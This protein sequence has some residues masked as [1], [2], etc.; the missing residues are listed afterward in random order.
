MSSGVP[1]TFC[2]KHPTWPP[3]YVDFEGSA[4]YHPD[5]APTSQGGL[6]KSL[7]ID[8]GVGSSHLHQPNQPSIYEPVEQ[9]RLTSYSVWDSVQILISEELGKI[10]LLDFSFRLLSLF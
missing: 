2:G 6:L 10:C 3:A 5:A 9:V 1:Q 7:L 4:C 8:P